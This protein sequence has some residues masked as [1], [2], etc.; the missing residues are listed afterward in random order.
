MRLMATSRRTF[1]R[2][3]GG[4]A[5]S[6]PFLGRPASAATSTA[7]TDDLI[8]G[9]RQE[10]NGGYAVATVDADGVERRIVPLPG[11]GHGAA[12]APS[13]GFVVFARRPGRFA[14]AVSA[15]RPPVTFAPP[16]DRHF[17]GH[18]VF[19][20]RG[21]LLYA[22]EN[23]FAHHRGVVGVYAPPDW[24]RVGEFPTH[25]IEPHE[26]VLLPDGETLCIANGGIVTDPEVGD[27]R[28]A[29]GEDVISDL[30]L[31]DRLSGALKDQWRLPHEFAP[32]SIRHLAV[33]H[34]GS[35]WFG[36]QWQGAKEATPPLIGRLT[37]EGKLQTVRTANLA[38]N[39][40]NYVG[41]MAADGSGRLIAASAPR[42]GLVVIVDAAEARVVGA[43]PLTDGCGLC[44]D[45][46]PGRFIA[47]SGM[48]ALCGVAI[49]AGATLEEELLRT[50]AAKW[51]NHLS[52]LP[53]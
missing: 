13:G 23:D 16:D 35:V 4:F 53:G 37:T 27:G 50:T 25:G 45:T 10:A 48:G 40:A 11:R 15:G 28:T 9:A 20:P 18:G 36:C 38:G 7:V 6:A 26:L 33:D 39:L 24:R 43:L 12:V 52:R 41:S 17:Y 49:G 51:D 19:S 32:L 3:A 2:A 21:D 22:T 30:V 14:V 8:V 47:S 5:C 29:I 42:A 34:A 1:L 31:V 46:R 44:A